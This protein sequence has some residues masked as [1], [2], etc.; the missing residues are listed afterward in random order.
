MLTK[1]IIPCLDIKN[2]KVVKGVKFKELINVGDPITLAKKY[3]EEGADEISFLDI[4]A[5]I[6]S[7]KTTINLVK[8]V[9][10]KIF[11]PISVG[12]GIKTIRE[13]RDLLNIGVEK[14]SIGS[15]AISNPML[16]K[17]ASER[18]GSQAIVLSIDAKKNQNLPSG[19]EVYIKGGREKTGIDALKF[20]NEMINLGAGEIL[21]NSID[22]DGTKSGYDLKLNSL[23]SQNLNVPIIASG[24]AGKIDDIKNVFLKGKADA[25]LVASV[26][27]NNIF[28]IK[29]VK[30][31]LKQKNIK[32][33]I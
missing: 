32:V 12:G 26:F 25:A 2:G 11:I 27:H 7:R 3:E 30:K 33:R 14:V 9:A 13:I 4:N 20:A 23:F 18:F 17:E 28:S 10:E 22:K 5:T 16:I 6:E 21:L 15:S 24:G 19:Y 1:R 31:Y 8:K 29:E